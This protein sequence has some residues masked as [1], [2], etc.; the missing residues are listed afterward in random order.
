MTK[1]GY[2]SRWWAIIS[3]PPDIS[4]LMKGRT[5]VKI[6]TN[7]RIQ[8]SGKKNRATV[9]H[10]V[11][12]MII[13]N[14]GRK[15]NRWGRREQRRTRSFG[16]RKRRGRS[17]GNVS[18]F[19]IISKHHLRKIRELELKILIKKVSGN[20]C[21]K[22]KAANLNAKKT[23]SSTRERQGKANLA[24]LVPSWSLALCS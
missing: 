17:R 13:R 3:I 21:T 22:T 18:S 4:N 2:K 20:R 7:R 16:R 14:F 10:R 6:I 5:L 12:M 15:R 1:R 9:T 19:M 11:C 8:R 23:Q 24:S